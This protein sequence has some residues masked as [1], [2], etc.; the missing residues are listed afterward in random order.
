MRIQYKHSAPVLDCCFH[1]A[2]HAYSGDCD[3]NLKCTIS[4]PARRRPSAA[5][6]DQSDASNT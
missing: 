1:D 3:N 5:I 6:G 4:T 2:T